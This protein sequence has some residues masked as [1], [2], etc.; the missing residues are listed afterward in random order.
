[1]H[2]SVPH[3]L[4]GFLLT[5]GAWLLMV[6][7]SPLQ[8]QGTTP[9]APTAQEAAWLKE[10]FDYARTAAASETSTVN[11]S[12]VLLGIFNLL[13]LFVVLVFI[14]RGGLKPLFDTVTA[15]RKR[16]S[17]AEK[18]E[19]QMRTI[20]DKRDREQD[21]YRRRTADTLERTAAILSGIES[22]QQAQARTDNAVTKIITDINTHTD[23]TMTDAKT[24]LEK[25]AEQVEQAAQTIGDV[26]TKDHLSNELKPI[27]EEL[28]D[29]AVTLREK[30]GTNPL[31]PA[32]VPD[33]DPALKPPA[34][35]VS[36]PA[37][38]SAAD[39]E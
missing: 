24:K 19:T 13:F 30:G 14:W 26:V 37:E 5:V 39:D 20:S 34:A 17:V 12:V 6:S 16:A 28:H 8:G 11:S 4:R 21:E 35:N 25:A 27:R 32:H 38:T 7:V 18:S 1:M 9:P 36:K 33:V 22:A 2:L 23:E 15:E 29:I 31:N 3:I 10:I